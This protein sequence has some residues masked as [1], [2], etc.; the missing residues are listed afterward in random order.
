MDM[1]MCPFF[2]GMSLLRLLVTLGSKFI[3]L[4]RFMLPLLT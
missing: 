1:Y 3:R 4:Y 2:G